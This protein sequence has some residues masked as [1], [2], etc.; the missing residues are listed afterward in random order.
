MDALKR[1][2]VAGSLSS[3]ASSATFTCADDS[4]DASRLCPFSTQVLLAAQHSG[5]R[6]DFLRYSARMR[7]S[8][9]ATTQLCCLLFDAPS[10]STTY[11]L[12]GILVVRGVH[13]DFSQPMWSR[14]V[15]YAS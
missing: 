5:E 6:A 8:L 2:G 11:V 13:S 4:H 12:H 9:F 10:R 15:V 7:H 14:S 3:A 1:Q